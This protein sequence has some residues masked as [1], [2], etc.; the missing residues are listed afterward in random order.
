MRAAA[1]AL[2][3]GFY[4]FGA[5]FFRSSTAFSNFRRVE[6][7][8]ICGAEKLYRETCLF[9]AHVFFR[10]TW[11]NQTAVTQS[12]CLDRQR[13]CGHSWYSVHERMLHLSMRTTT[14][15]TR[16]ERGR[17]Y[18]Q[19]VL[20]NPKYVAAIHAFATNDA[21]VARLVWSRTVRQC[22]NENTNAL[23][24]IRIALSQC[25]YDQTKQF[26]S[27]NRFFR[28]AR[29]NPEALFAAYRR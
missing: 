13:E 25:D 17:D 3:Y 20:S 11:T 12:L 21:E 19:D 5:L 26:L 27:T 28:P 2:A 24:Q 8:S 14:R 16:K 15:W 7:C 23:G 22:F 9:D 4:Q 18:G 29:P 6:L 1:L 10:T